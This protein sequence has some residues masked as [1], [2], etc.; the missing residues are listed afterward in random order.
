MRLSLVLGFLSGAIGIVL[1]SLLIAGAWPIYVLDKR[2]YEGSLLR[3]VSLFFQMVT[4]TESFS[5]ADNYVT[6]THTNYNDFGEMVRVDDQPI[7]VGNH[8]VISSLFFLSAFTFLVLLVQVV[9]IRNMNPKRIVIKISL[10]LACGFGAAALITHMAA[11]YFI[12]GERGNPFVLHY[13]AEKGYTRHF[14]Q[15]SFIMII[16]PIIHLIGTSFTAFSLNKMLSS[17]DNSYLMLR[18]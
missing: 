5:G 17:L 8:L 3:S 10:V 2:F 16:C 18:E 12:L 15:C 9:L 13:M 6:S 11:A 7:I 1:Q 14:S 4:V